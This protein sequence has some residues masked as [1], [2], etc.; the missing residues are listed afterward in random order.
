MTVGVVL[1]VWPLQAA[2]K[3]LE[4]EKAAR[5]AACDKHSSIMQVGHTIADAPGSRTISLGLS[6]RRVDHEGPSSSSAVGER[7]AR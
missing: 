3:A 2:A 6:S 7:G 5:K 1:L 4:E